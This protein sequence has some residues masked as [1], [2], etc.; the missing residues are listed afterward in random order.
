MH[1]CHGAPGAVQAL[2]KAYERTGDR[3]LLDAAAAASDVVWQRGL[4]RKGPG[5]CHGLAGNG[6]AFLALHRATQGASGRHL[7][8]AQQ[9]AR[10]I[11]HRQA[12]LG[13]A[14]PDVT[15]K[16]SVGLMDGV[17]GVVCFLVD[18]VAETQRCAAGAAGSAAATAAAVPACPRAA[19]AAGAAAAAGAVAIAAS[20]SDAAPGSASTAPTGAGAGS[21]AG[22]GARS[23]GGASCHS[24]LRQDAATRR[25]AVVPSCVP[26]LPPA[27]WMP[28]FE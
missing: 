7:H 27:S 15:S 16:M 2:C 12:L 10:A 1:W 20:P 21:G 8:R 28:G 18:V 22:A 23:G 25:A 19:P 6:Y 17:S 13:D 26:A 5:L 9:F 24:A 3:T 14:V 11:V 4:L